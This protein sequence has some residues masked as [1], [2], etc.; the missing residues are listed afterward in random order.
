[1]TDIDLTAATAGLIDA[2]A[3]HVAHNYHPLPVVV[4]EGEG[5]WVT[6]V[7]GRR[8]LDLLSAYSALNFGHRHPALVAAATEQLGRLTLTS[9]A[10]HNDRLGAFAS[11][12][13]TLSGKDMV[14]PMNTGA[15][16]VETGIKVARAWAYRVKGVPEGAAEIIVAAGNFHGRTTTIVGFSDDPQAR[17]GFGPF[18]PGFTMV[19]YGDA[20]AL[21]AAIGPHTAA[22]L[23]EPIQGEAGV[24]IPPEGYLREV[25]ELTRAQQ[26]LFIA[27]EIQSGLGRV[28]T[29]FACDR[30]EVVPDLYLLGKALG[31]GILPLSAVVGD[32]DV[33][34][35][36]HPGEHG[37]TFGGNPLAAA[38]GAA[39]VDLLATGDLQRRALALGEHLRAQLEPLIGSGVTSIRVAGLWA[40]VDIDPA[41]GTGR[42]V[43]ER[44]LARGVL[45]KDTH[46]QTIRMAPPLVIR[47]TEIDWAVEQLK[48]VLAG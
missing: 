20:A 24:V 39:V 45:V 32:R 18:T 30:E 40:G 23:I 46:G 1:M 29:T 43:A 14:L 47:A 15:E 4:A 7:E 28:G 5:S 42:E 3:E 9:R 38:V 34:G 26:V 27:D 48:L 37:S 36:I 16:A 21:A 25:R 17:D 11:A 8:Y 35:V 19:P 31:G 12:L 41:A 33:L 22:V 2:E 6:D 44:L 13:S 10:F